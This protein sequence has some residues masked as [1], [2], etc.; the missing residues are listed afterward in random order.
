M[1]VAINSNKGRRYFFICYFKFEEHGS[2]AVVTTSYSHTVVAN[3][4]VEIESLSPVCKGEYV[5]MNG[6][7]CSVAEALGFAETCI[8]Y[9]PLF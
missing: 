5:G 3:P 9:L 7:P 2:Q 1:A 4:V 8:E 6:A